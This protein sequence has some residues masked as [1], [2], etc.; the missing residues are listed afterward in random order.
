MKKMIAFVL[1]ICTLIAVF[2]YNGCTPDE[3]ERKE[4]DEFFEN[5]IKYTCLDTVLMIIRGGPYEMGNSGIFHYLIT[6]GSGLSTG[7]R[8]SL[9][10]LDTTHALYDTLQCVPT[11]VG[12]GMT[13]KRVFYEAR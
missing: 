3:Q 10:T 2:F 9:F 1:V 13:H 4:A 7:E 6:G 5:P 11:S 8:W 12:I